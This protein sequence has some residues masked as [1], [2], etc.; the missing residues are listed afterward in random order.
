MTMTG[1][2]PGMDGKA[3]KYKSVTEYTDENSMK[4][5]MYMGAAKEPGFT[6]LY[7]KKK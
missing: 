5:S 1:E 6:I 4:F 7:K 3:T 2:G